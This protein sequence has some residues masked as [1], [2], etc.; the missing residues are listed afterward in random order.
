MEGGKAVEAEEEVLVEVTKSRR[1]LFFEG[2]SV[3]VGVAVWRVV[4]KGRLRLGMGI[5]GGSVVRRLGLS[6][7][8]IL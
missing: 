3:A 7:E 1:A 8:R 5:G 2:R 4:V 6:K